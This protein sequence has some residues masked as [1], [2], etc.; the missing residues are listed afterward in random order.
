M[1][2][3][4]PHHGDAE[5]RGGHR[6]IARA[7]ARDDHGVGA[8]RAAQPPRDHLGAHE[9]RHADPDVE[10]LVAEL[11]A[12]QCPE[13]PAEPKLGQVAGLQQEPLRQEIMANGTRFA[14]APRRS[15]RDRG[16]SRGR[17]D[18]REVPGC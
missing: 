4:P 3:G 9:H 13:D 15:E 14:A 5:P 18:G 7:Q 6:E 16:G 8:A 10:E 12:L 1:S 2:S 17:S 11:G